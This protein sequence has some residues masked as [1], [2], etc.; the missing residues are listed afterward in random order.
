MQD[1][2]VVGKDLS[3]LVRNM[4]KVFNCVPAKQ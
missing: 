4:V 2:H 3:G 1:L